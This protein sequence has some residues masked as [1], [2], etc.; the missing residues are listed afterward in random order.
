MTRKIP[1]G[2][3]RIG[4]GEPV[5]VIAEIGINHEGD[6]E[7]CARM[8]EAAAAAGA[9]SIKLQT[10]DA[11]ENY[12]RGTE[13]HELFSRSALTREETARMFDLARSL[14]LEP[15][16]TAGDAATIEWVTTL[17]PAAH[18]ISSGLL[19]NHPAIRCAS[20]SGAPLLIS[21]GMAEVG[22]IDDAVA[23]ARDGGAN[24]LGLFQCTSLYPAPPESLNLAAIG[25]LAERYDMP[26]GFSDHSLGIA[27]AALSV[28]AGAC[29]IEK[30]FTLDASRPSYDHHLSLEPEA[31]AEM[32]RGV[33]TAE[34]MRG[35][36]VKQPTEAE[37]GRAALYHRIVVA[38]RDMAPGEILDDGSVALKRPLPGMRG[39]PPA[40][41]QDLLGRRT[42]R[43][44]ARDEAIVAAD[45]TPP[46]ND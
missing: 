8:I 2:A 46:L 23:A 35:I 36:P 20:R 27:A 22:D 10:V 13:S 28:A 38:R 31:F 44:I 32:V 19:T 34:A 45:V 21:T 41:Y 43:R 7:A 24:G 5:V 25:W 30:H 14:G 29:M 39:L 6:A 9:D 3:R 17:R 15:F 11:D 33:R 1:F 42:T 37:R 12:L 40:R 4:E 26:A 16:T 18:K